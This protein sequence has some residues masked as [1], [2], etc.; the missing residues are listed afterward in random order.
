MIRIVADP[1]Q[2]VPEEGKGYV[3]LPT[4]VYDMARVQK[5]VPVI[6]ETEESPSYWLPVILVLVLAILAGAWYM[7]KSG[8][9]PFKK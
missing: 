7:K 6:E 4:N 2:G 5:P 8:K 1:L 9:G 3:L